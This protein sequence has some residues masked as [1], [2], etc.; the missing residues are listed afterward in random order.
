MPSN[1]PCLLQ[2]HIKKLPSIFI[3]VVCHLGHQFRHSPL[4]PKSLY[5][6]TQHGRRLISST[7]LI[8]VFYLISM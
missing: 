7:S 3:A 2:I 1:L 6:G 5:L 4:T 8:V